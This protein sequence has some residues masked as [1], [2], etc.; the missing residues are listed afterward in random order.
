MLSHLKQYYGAHYWVEARPRLAAT[1]ET[2]NLLFNLPENSTVGIALAAVAAVGVLM[3]LTYWRPS[4]DRP[5]GTPDAPFHE[6]ILALGLLAL[7][8]VFLVAM[9]IVHGGL[10]VRYLLETVLGFS[11]AASYILPRL[12]RRS[13]I[14]FG[15]LIAVAIV[16]QEVPLWLQLKTAP[17]TASVEQL[18]NDAGFPELP[19]VVSDGLN[20]L[21]VV[22]YASPNV[23]GRYVSLVDLLGSMTYL[24]TD[25]VDK[26]LLLLRRYAPLQVYESRDFLVKNQQFLLY[27][28]GNAPWDW[29]P[30]RLLDDRYTLRLLVIHDKEKIYLV[31]K[32]N[33]PN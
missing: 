7:P 32:Q 23:R 11:L 17:S 8:F 4:E 6:K 33:P 18:A 31:T 19:V 29:W 13:A 9:K 26:N 16:A 15:V 22:H 2:Y 5:H 27:S 20:Y 24:R 28:S 1:A 25:F 10:V 30:A 14:L 21:K 12:C 3:T